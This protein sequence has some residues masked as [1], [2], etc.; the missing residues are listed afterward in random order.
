M[1]TPGNTTARGYGYAHQKQRKR[2]AKVI[3]QQGGTPCARCGGW[4]DAAEPWDLGHHDHDRS[5]Y[6]GPEHRACNRATSGRRT[7]PGVTTL[8]W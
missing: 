4:I 1:T 6:T 3:A 7:T 8:R 2:W 5:I